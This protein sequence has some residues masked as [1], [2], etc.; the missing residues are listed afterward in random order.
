MSKISNT[1]PREG[2]ALASTSINSLFS[3]FVSATSTAMQED[4]LANESIDVTQLNL[5]S[6][7]SGENS[8]ILKKMRHDQ[9]G[10]ASPGVVVA[11][12][13]GTGEQV[14][15]IVTNS[16]S[17]GASGI[18]FE[19]GD[20]IRVYH[21]LV[22]TLMG[23][24]ASDF[25]ATP[26]WN[27]ARDKNACWAVWLEYASSWA[28]APSGW[29]PVVNQDDFNTNIGFFSGDFYYGSQ[30]TS[31]RSTAIVPH[32]MT[33]LEGTPA[34]PLDAKRIDTSRQNF[35]GQYYYKFTG[36]TTWYGMRLRIGGLFWAYNTSGVNWLAYI[37]GYSA[38]NTITYE[39]GEITLIQMRSV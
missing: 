37:P 18:S 27:Q 35:H 29:T 24:D 25:P 22:T 3:D 16:V 17:Y 31:M 19:T 21:N 8:F 10:S 20:F 11:S 13:T 36:N 38:S 33:Y 14:W 39:E 28:G 15:D 6:V 32:W 12:K 2:D 30:L 9:I 4:N 7:G 1:L 34:S 5:T 26:T 23:Y